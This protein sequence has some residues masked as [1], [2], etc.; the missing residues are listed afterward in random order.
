MD[1]NQA[2]LQ[3]LKSLT[4][5]KK[6]HGLNTGEVFKNHCAKF[7]FAVMFLIHHYFHPEL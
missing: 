5:N 7:N 6:P 3:R 4:I 2:G 1:L